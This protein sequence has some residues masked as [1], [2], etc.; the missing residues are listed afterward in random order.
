MMTMSLV[1]TNPEFKAMHSHNVE[2]KKM[3]KMRSIMKLCSN[4]ARILAGMARSGEAY[5]THK[6]LPL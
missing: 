2:V 3:N 1:M 4:L 6:T 5:A